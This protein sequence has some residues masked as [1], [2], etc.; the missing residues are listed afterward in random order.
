MNEETKQTIKILIL[1]LF[2][3]GLGYWSNSPTWKIYTSSSYESDVE[4]DRILNNANRLLRE[5]GKGV[6]LSMMDRE[7]TMGDIYIR[8]YVSWETYRIHVK[9]RGL[10]VFIAESDDFFYVR[11]NTFTDMGDWVSRLERGMNS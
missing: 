5:F 10:I 11:I 1:M 4:T 2:I 9:H 8:R 6:P 3:F 7:L